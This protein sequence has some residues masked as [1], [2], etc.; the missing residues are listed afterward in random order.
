MFAEF[1]EYVFPRIDVVWRVCENE[2]VG[3][4]CEPR[5]C[6]DGISLVG[7]SLFGHVSGNGL[8]SYLC[9]SSAV[10]FYEV[11]VFSAMFEE[12]EADGSGAG[13]EVER[14]H[15]VCAVWTEHRD[16]G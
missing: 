4:A 13:V 5:Q 12:V 14:G 9:G 2:V 1:G 16:D 8:L 15:S 7:R 6:L 3:V 11:D 10:D